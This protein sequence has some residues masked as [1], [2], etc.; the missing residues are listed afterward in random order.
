MWWLQLNNVW[1]RTRSN[2]WKI[3]SVHEHLAYNVKSSDIVCWDKRE[4]LTTVFNK[5]IKVEI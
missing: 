2:D 5:K 4:W 3:Y 1:Y